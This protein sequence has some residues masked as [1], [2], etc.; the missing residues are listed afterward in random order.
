MFSFYSRLI[1]LLSVTASLRKSSPASSGL[2]KHDIAA[3]AQHDR[4]GMAENGRDLE[5]SG[6]L[7]VHEETI[8]ALD[9]ALELMSPG[10]EFG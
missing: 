10:L 5:A 1:H 8:R 6:A 2:T 3:T 9:K 7:D 4:L